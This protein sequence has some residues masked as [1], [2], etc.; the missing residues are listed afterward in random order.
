MES[1]DEA[2]VEL[3][4]P[5]DKNDVE[6]NPAL[7]SN[8]RRSVKFYKKFLLSSYPALGD[9]PTKLQQLKYSLLLPPHGIVAEVLTKVSFIFINHNI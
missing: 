9:N 2:S 5:A 6:N 1:G 4:S 7:T 3:K 8:R